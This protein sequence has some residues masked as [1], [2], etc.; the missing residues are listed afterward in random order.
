MFFVKAGQRQCW[1]SLGFWREHRVALWMVLAV[2][3]FLHV[4]EPHVLRMLYDEPTHALTA[5]EMHLDK[6]AVTAGQS[7]Y[8]GDALI[9]SRQNPS[10]RQYLFPLA[11]SLLHDFTG[12]RLANV[13]V[14]NGLIT[15]VILLEA[16]FLAYKLGGK[17]AGYIAVAMLGA[18]P[19]LAQVVTS[20]EYDALNLG[21]I[22]MLILFTMAYVQSSAQERGSLMDLS[23]S[24]A[25]LVAVARTESV[26][27]LLPWSLVTLLLWW[28]ERDVKLTWFAVISPLFVLPNLMVTLLM[29]TTGLGTDLEMRKEGVAL[30]SI[31][32]LPKHLS[33]AIYYFFNFSRISTN[34]VLLVAI[35][36]I[37]IIAFIVSLLGA[38]RAGRAIRRELVF[39]IFAVWV[40]LVYMVVLT[41]FW[42]SPVDSM[43]TRFCLPFMFVC[44]V[45]AGWFLVQFS[46][47]R[48]H[49]SCI[50]S[51]LLLWGI[52]VAAPSA[53][54][55]FSTHGSS[56]GS[57]E[58]WY[59][60]YAAT[61]DMRTT[62]FV[63][64]SNSSFASRRYAASVLVYLNGSPAVFVRA[65]KAG[66]YHDIIVFQSMHP[67][68]KVGAWKI[69]ATDK[70]SE[71]IVLE[72]LEERIFTP[73]YKARISRLVGYK[74]ADGTLIVPSGNA[75]EIELK[76][77]FADQ[78][79]WY[80]YYISLYP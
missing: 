64:R 57:A 5:L 61:R 27:Y 38:V 13:F 75:P 9:L 39:V 28:R 15:L 23:L 24:T 50:L 41:H 26:L 3:I 30:V 34:N 78:A 79:E 6:Q 76:Q 42:S 48:N 1:F 12:Y 62:L 63:A 20:G 77:T 46:W 70:I 45:A 54:R 22:G 40:A 2:A 47:L 44:A 69:A 55:A 17:L 67:D 72:T 16:Y 21:V 33:E 11:V 36:M 80:D 66:L 10:F 18:L 52:L 8:I 37:G 43:A 65:L 53:S 31:T 19:L 71:N 7:N 51:C 32:Y 29:A 68:P 35:G 58:E 60:Q 49:P 74:R 25:L 14:L 59:L 4:H 73:A 56:T